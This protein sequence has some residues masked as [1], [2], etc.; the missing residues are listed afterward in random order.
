MKSLKTFVIREKLASDMKDKELK[1]WTTKPNAFLVAKI[2][3]KVVGCISYKQINQDTVEMNR[4]A[5]DSNHRGL[6]IGRKLVEALNDTAK[7]EG[8]NTMYLEKSDAQ[9]DALKM[10]EKMGFSFLRRMD[11]GHG[12]GAFFVNHFSGLCVFA[13]IQRL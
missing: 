9:V 8:Y 12:Y 1:F 2:N 7:N 3:G 10:Y 5:V 6:R 4:L 13:Y 11:F